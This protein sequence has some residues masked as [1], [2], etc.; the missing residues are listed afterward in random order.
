MSASET[1]YQPQREE[2]KCGYSAVRIKGVIEVAPAAA[3]PVR[4]YHVCYAPVFAA[5]SPI[6]CLL[7][8]ILNAIALFFLLLFF[9]F[10]RD[11][12]LLC[13][14]RRVKFRMKHCGDGNSDPNLVLDDPYAEH[15]HSWSTTYGKDAVWEQ[16]M[17]DN[18][19]R[20][21]PV[22]QRAV[23]RPSTLLMAFRYHTAP[24]LY[25][26]PWASEAEH[27]QAREA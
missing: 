27:M 12:A 3:D 18:R 14:I 26:P 4:E 25:S 2:A 9:L 10:T 13:A 19:S 7:L 6:V 16:W 15:V 23:V 1:W 20:Y 22:F 24:I 11:P 17:L 5:H 8:S 21:E